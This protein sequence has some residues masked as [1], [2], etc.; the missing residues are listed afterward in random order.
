MFPALQKF[1]R[2][3]SIGNN[4]TP[5]STT[6]NIRV[7]ESKRESDTQEPKRGLWSV[8]MRRQPKQIAG[9]DFHDPSQEVFYDHQVSSNALTESARLGEFVRVGVIDV[10]R[11]SPKQL[12]RILQ[13]TAN[14]AKAYPL[15]AT[16]RIMG[17]NA[18][19][20]RFV[21]V[22]AKR[23]MHD[24]FNLNGAPPEFNQIFLDTVG[25]VRRKPWKGAAAA[26]YDMPLP[27]VLST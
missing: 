1:V 4:A 9:G 21:A 15:Q 3:L 26:Q 25:E 2:T 16:F 13:D 17:F 23:A 6:A 8:A 11:S 24:I 14:A 7:S 22:D 12:R 20:K 10:S 18:G 19:G 5:P 27:A